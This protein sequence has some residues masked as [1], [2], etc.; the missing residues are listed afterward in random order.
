MAGGKLTARQKMINMMYLVL[1]SLLALNVSKEIIKTFNLLENSLDKS[2][3][4]IANKSEQLRFSLSQKAHQ[5]NEKA[6]EAHVIAMEVKNTADAFYSYV[7]NIKKELEKRANGRAENNAKQEGKTELKE[8]DNI[9]KHAHFFVG[10]K[11]GEKVEK[12]TN[13]TRKKLIGAIYKAKNNKLLNLNHSKDAYFNEKI[14]EL[15]GK[16]TLVAEATTDAEGKKVSWTGMFL[17]NSPLAGVMTILSK[18]QN[19][20]RNLESEVTQTLAESVGINNIEVDSVYP[21]IAASTSAIL[22]GQTY[23]ADLFLA[24]YNSQSAMQ[25]TVNGQPVQVEGGKGKFR[26]T[27]NTPGN[28][29]YK[30]AM[31]LPGSTKTFTTEGQYSVF[32]PMASVS[33]DELQIFYVGME[34]PITVSAAG[35]K[36]EDI[37]ISSTVGTIE[38]VSNGKYHVLIPARTANECTINISAR[39]ADGRV[40][41]LSTQ[42]FRIRNVSKPIGRVGPI[43]LDKPTAI[44]ELMVQN[45]LTASNPD[46]PYQSVS[47][48]ITSYRY[49]LLGSGGR[50]KTGNVNGS[51]IAAL[52]EAL[53]SAKS[54]DYLMLDNIFYSGPDGIKPLGGIGVQ[55]K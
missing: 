33:C 37:I 11:N 4:N 44:A 50:P 51:S 46:F 1:T 14:A 30:V 41:P 2:T 9:E 15:E 28:Y 45:N 36:P 3:L 22:T 10:E 18:I 39:G 26:I 8:G 43:S 40:M 54:G 17:E 16:S 21:V 12:Q 25:I 34:N 19:D 53:R 42:K 32:S 35:I 23:E 5:D 55:L 52:K 6:R 29:N 20:C 13:D 38:R 27:G 31:N 47:Y 24:A 49:T 48:R 7:E